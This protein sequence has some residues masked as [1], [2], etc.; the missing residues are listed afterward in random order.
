MASSSTQSIITLVFGVTA[1]AVSAVT[2][3]QGRKFWRVWHN[4]HRVLDLEEDTA[5]RERLHLSMFF[6]LLILSPA[7]SGARTHIRSPD[8]RSQ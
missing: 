5:S 4:R 2:V 1:T 7:R 6:L 3:W 8:K